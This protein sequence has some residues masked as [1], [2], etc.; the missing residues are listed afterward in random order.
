[1]LDEGSGREFLSLIRTSARI[2][3][4]NWLFIIH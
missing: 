2:E 4:E 3:I 1:M